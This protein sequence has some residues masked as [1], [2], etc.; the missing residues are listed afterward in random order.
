MA[1]AISLSVTN[2]A[3]VSLGRC[4]AGRAP[5]L[6]SYGHGGVSAMGRKLK[7][8][9][10]AFLIRIPLTSHG[11]L[12]RIP[13]R[14]S[15]VE[16]DELHAGNRSND[17]RNHAGWLSSAGAWRRTLPGCASTRCYFYWDCTLGRKSLGQR[18]R[19]H[20]LP[21]CRSCCGRLVGL[22]ARDPWRPDFRARLQLLLHRAASHLSHQ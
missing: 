15:S 11:E 22:W 14:M 16:H 5:P 20:D 2:V 21:S 4:Q 3:S 10:Y 18:A 7:A 8:A 19:R 12:T 9:T 6:K 1:V 17:K 13:A